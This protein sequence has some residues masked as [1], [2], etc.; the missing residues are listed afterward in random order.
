MAVAQ[1]IPLGNS[2]QFHPRGDGHFGDEEEKVGAFSS[3]TATYSSDSQPPASPS[4][5][6]TYTDTTYR[7]AA[8]KG[9]KGTVIPKLAGV[10]FGG[11]LRGNSAFC[12]SGDLSRT[13]TRT[14]LFGFV[15]TVTGG[16]RTRYYWSV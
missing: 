10:L 5:Q 16:P 4:D 11:K 6:R 1:L 15:N 14:Q 8:F 12:Q 3:F 9:K 13:L 7:A 2:C